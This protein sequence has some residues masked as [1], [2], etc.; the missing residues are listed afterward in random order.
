MLKA[1][2]PLQLKRL[3]MVDMTIAERSA[4]LQ[5]QLGVLAETQQVLVPICACT[6]LFAPMVQYVAGSD[7][8]LA[9]IGRSS[10]LSI[11]WQDSGISL[12][13]RVLV[14]SLSK[15]HE[16]ISMHRQASM[17]QKEFLAAVF[18]STTST[19]SSA[20][21]P[22]LSPSAVWLQCNPVC[23]FC[24]CLQ[25]SLDITRRKSQETATLC[26]VNQAA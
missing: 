26:P 15:A 22:C 23:Q 11:P 1:E 18:L 19:P 13:A 2:R 14:Y 5:K 16:G 20:A 8:T 17:Q 25:C 9:S 4:A 10:C 21:Q 24:H 3:Q 6:N 12:L 7:A